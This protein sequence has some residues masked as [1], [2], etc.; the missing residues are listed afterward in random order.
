MIDHALLKPSLTE[1]ELDTGIQLACDLNVASVCIMP[2]ALKQAAELLQESPVKASTVIGFPHGVNTTAVKVA[3]VHQ[4]LKDGA[5]ELD[6]VVNIPWVVSMHWT[7]VYDDIKAMTEPIH[8]AGAKIKVIFENA[9]L[10]DRQK[11]RLCEI[12]TEL[13]V[14]WVKTSTGF[15]SSGATDHD[16]QLMREHAGDRVQVKASGGIKT[17]EDALRVK[18]LGVTRIG[19]SGTAE[20]LEAARQRDTQTV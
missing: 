15:A 12:C 1:E 20:I 6:V 19:M 3:E 17:L 13:N 5:D 4:A 18:E 10:T 16:L 11:A 2:F 9:Y 8:D 7:K 14:D